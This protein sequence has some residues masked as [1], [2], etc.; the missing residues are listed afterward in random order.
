M[1]HNH[2]N[3]G[4]KDTTEKN[5][6][7]TMF[8]NFFITIV[9]FAGGLISGSLSLISDSLHNFS[10]GIAI[11]ITYIAMR[12]SKKPRTLKHT[13]GLKRAEILAA[14]INASTLIVI[15]FFLIKEA[16][17]RFYNPTPITAGLML[18]VASL[19]LLANAAGTVLLRKGTENN[20][21]MRAAY[22]HL[23]SDAVSSLAVIVGALFIIFLKVYWIDPVLTILISI[24][25][26]KETFEIVKQAVDV[27]IMTAPSEIDLK[28]VSQTIE[29]ILKV[30]NVHHVHVWK[31][32]DADTHFEAH[33]EVGDISVCETG[34][35]QKQIE[36]T[37]LDMFGINHIT[38][39]FECN[40]CETKT[41]I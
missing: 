33:I 26:L 7:I 24:Y 21:N 11:I 3:S 9:E 18:V 25:I 23:L 37:L 5:L 35:I 27:I 2:S 4:A 19:G 28:E 16:I 12:I 34:E 29:S 6:I 31:L 14:I 32:N 8:L 20:L 17:E 30:K 39:Q 38:L 41:I 15:S 22:F 10:D 40:M 13:F 36:H 1:S